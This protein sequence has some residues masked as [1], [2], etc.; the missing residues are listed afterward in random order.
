MRNSIKKSNN[1]EQSN[2]VTQ[3]KHS[4]FES[5]TDKECCHSNVEPPRL[6]RLNLSIRAPRSRALVITRNSS[7][8]LGPVMTGY[9]L[10]CIR[11][12]LRKRIDYLENIRRPVLQPL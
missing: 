5:T 10:S 11:T 6:P 3:T 8:G 2:S 4:F 1:G 12:V 9:V 7:A